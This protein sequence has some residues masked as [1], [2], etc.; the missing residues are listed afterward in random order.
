MTT[1]IVE[2]VIDGKLSK[3]VDAETEDA[4]EN[5]VISE[6]VETYSIPGYEPFFK[7]INVG[8]YEPDPVTKTAKDFINLLEEAGIKNVVYKNEGFKETVEF[9]NIIIVDFRNNGTI[10]VKSN[11]ISLYPDHFAIGCNCIMLQ[12]CH[13]NNMLYYSIKPEMIANNAK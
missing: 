8:V 9:D 13:D 4:A 1:Y 11:N 7:F 5:K 12:D 2:F 10:H 3:K 6:I